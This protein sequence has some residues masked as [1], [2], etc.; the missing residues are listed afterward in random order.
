VT[1]GDSS[2]QNYTVTVTVALSPAKAITAFSLN[3]V[4]GTIDEAAKTIALTLPHGTSVT[5]LVATFTTTGASVKVGSSVQ[6]SGTT[7]NN[8]TNSVTYKV[9]AADSST[10]N[11][12]VTVTVALSPAKAITAFSLK[13]VTGTIN[14]AN[15]AIALILPPVTNVTALVATFITTGQSVKVGSTVQASGTTAN[16]FTN[17]VTYKV[18]AADGTMA[19]YTVIVTL[20]AWHHPV[21]INDNI[22][23]TGES[24]MYPQV[25]MDNNGNAIIVWEQ[26]DGTNDQ[27]FKSEYRNGVWHHPVSLSDNISPD[28]GFESHD[29][30]PQVAMDNNGNAIIVWSQNDGTGY[31]YLYK[32]EYRNGVWT[33]PSSISDSINFS[34]HGNWADVAMDDN[35]NAIIVWPGQ[36]TAIYKSEYRNGVWSHPASLS[37]K[38]SPDG[39]DGVGPNVAMDNNGNA[40]I[41]WLCYGPDYHI[42]KS[43]YRNGVW[44]HPASLSD[45]INPG[46]TDAGEP[47]VA[48]DNNGNAIIAWSQCN[49]DDIY[50]VFKSEY[51]NGTWTHPSSLADYISPDSQDLYADRRVQVAMDNNGNAIIAWYQ[52]DGAKYQIYKSEYRNGVWIHPANLTDNI[53]PDGIGAFSPQVK[54]DDKGSALIV[55]AQSDGANSQIFKSEYRNGVWIHPAN[56]TDNI[57]P[58]GKFAYVPQV[59]MDDKN[60]AI[61]VWSQFEGDLQI[62]KSEYR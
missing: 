46:G 50:K 58:D 40:I 39:S 44:T 60:N 30:L 11:Y 28:V 14:E 10:Q 35:G 8:F 47:Q 41:V 59:E 19:Y 29:L 2:T 31:W 57:S 51:R 56:L 4:T 48:M 21:S 32:S 3:G 42:F 23:P 37:D 16:N 36:K 61:I 12:T 24:A 1:A 9:T 13:G 7:A 53:S 27:V 49:K 26:S 15:K 22:S 33:H 20:G 38:I 43:E 6:V 62:F 55:W 45:Y 5:A 54:M 52:P 17:P 18:T 34:L 25:A